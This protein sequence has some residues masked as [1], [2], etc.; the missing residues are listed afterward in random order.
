ML[1]YLRMRR[2]TG[3]MMSQ[4][5][6]EDFPDLRY[7]P[8]FQVIA[9]LLLVPL[10]TAGEDFIVFFRRGQLK[11]VRW[12]GNPYEKMVKEGTQA[13]LEPRKSFKTWRENVTGKCREWSEEEIETAAVLCLVY[14]KFITVWRQKEAALQSSQLTRL[15]LANSAHEVRTPLNAIINYLEIALEG[16][17]DQETRDSLAK[18]HSASK[19][20]IYVINDLLDLTKTEEGHELTK[21]DI[22]S[23]TQTIREVTDMFRGDAKRKQLEFV[24]TEHPGV[25]GLVIGDQRRTQQA[26]S[27]IIANAIQNTV[28]GGVTVECWVAHREGRRVD[29]EIAVQDTGAGMAASKLDALFREL[30]QVQTE[31]NHSLTDSL[32]GEP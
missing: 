9:G 7:P 26:L 28:T 27:N 31:A 14:G 17:L 5:L 10:S 8:G 15:L 23:L 25:P 32:S 4:D 30:E 16:S 22:F 29:V 20:L 6:R 11:E 12:A 19:S 2:F 1:E 21:D 13:F 3:V 24:L 18:S